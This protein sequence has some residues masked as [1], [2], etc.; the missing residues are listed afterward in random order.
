MKRILALMTALCLLCSA[1]LAQNEVP[2]AVVDGTACGVTIWRNHQEMDTDQQK[3]VQDY[4]VFECADKQFE[5]FLTENI[6]EPV[7]EMC[8][9]EAGQARGGYYASLDFDGVLSVEASAHKLPEG[10]QETEVEL[11]YAIVD[12]NGKR[13]LELQDLFTEPEPVVVEVICNAV[14]EQAAELELL[15]E[16]ITDSGLVPLPDSYYLTREALRVLYDTNTLS[17]QAVALDL[18]WEELPLSWSAVLTGESIIAEPEMDATI[19]IIGGAD[20][21]TSIF[22]TEGAEVPEEILEAYPNAV[23]AT[24][25]PAVELDNVENTQTPVLTVVP[26]IT[27]EP[28]VTPAVIVE[29]EITPAPFV[30][31]VPTVTPFPVETLN[32]DFSLAPVITPTPMPVAGSD[33]MMVDVL[34]HGLWKPLGT[35]GNVYY[36]F[37]ADGKLLTV[38]VAEYSVKDGVLTSDVLNGTLDIGSDSA[39]VL[40]DGSDMSGYV[41]NR[42]GERVAPEEF[43]TP[44][45]TPVPTPTPTP[46]PT[47]SPTPSPTPAP[48]PTPTPKPTPTPTP[49]PTPVPTPTPTP[50][51]SPY[52][53]A[54]AAA[55]V[56]E[57]LEDPSFEHVRTLKVYS[58]PDE[59]SWTASGAQVTT[60]DTVAIY[61]VENGWVLV[62]YAIGDGS[63]G[64]MGYIADTTLANPEKTRK[65]GFCSL[66]MT[67]TQNAKATDDP[68][69]SRN[70]LTT[71]RKGTEVTLLA[72]FEKNWAY[73]Q[74]TYE[75]KPCRLFIPVSALKED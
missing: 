36:Q 1:A 55:P 47:P 10:A 67:L 60:D 70:T 20:G 34:T 52:Q 50:T 63:R 69:R 66:P 39:F 14:Y 25:E 3:M 73:V 65:L 59:T 33:A 64:R 15:L 35:E 54:L 13:L 37:T 27:L 45:P 23:I 21:P 7:R 31:P 42:Q 22:I 2:A 6:T 9:L 4:P 30:T 75:G 32:P 61:G 58:A 46:T 56:I 53:N 38:S 48:T 49:T 74:T 28:T 24:A 18:N 51:L 71:L 40:R 43:V 5:Q 44:S 26:V 16:S 57:A 29:T 11:F 68:L 41:L 62:S 19:G 12:L 8:M 72:F 17:E